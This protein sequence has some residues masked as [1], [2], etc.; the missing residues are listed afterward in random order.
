MPESDERRELLDAVRDE[1]QHLSE[2]YRDVITLHFFGNMDYQ[3]LCTALNCPMGT[4]KARMHRGL[5]K[6]KERLSGVG[7][8]VPAGVL[9]EVLKKSA[10]MPKVTLAADQ[11]QRLGQLMNRY[12]RS[13]SCGMATE[14][15]AWGVGKLIAVG[16]LAA[17]GWGGYMLMSSPP[18]EKPASVSVPTGSDFRYAWDFT[19]PDLPK[20]LICVPGTLRYIPDQGIDN[21]GCIETVEMLSKF[22]LNLP[23]TDLPLYITFREKM[24]FPKKNTASTIPVSP[25][26]KTKG[27]VTSIGW[28]PNSSTAF[29]GISGK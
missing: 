22:Y 14:T 25:D 9:Y 1:L 20:E 15:A 27:W 28:Y 3:E 17:A 4:I 18:F 11:T 8:V 21:S 12:A 5:E 7:I 6:L 13:G 16:L 24:I 10:S 26:G 2:I 19:K 23:S 29:S